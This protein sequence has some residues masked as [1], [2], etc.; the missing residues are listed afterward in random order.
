MPSRRHLQTKGG[1]GIAEA[2]TQR[3][4]A[5]AAA[6]ADAPA[7]L[8]DAAFAAV[9]AQALL[10][11]FRQARRPLPWRVTYAPYHVWVSEIMLQQTQMERGVSYFQRW[12]AELPDI[13]AVAAASE[14]T[15]LRLWEGLGYYSR[16][17]NLH[18]AAR[19]IMAEHGGVFPPSFEAIRALPGVGPYTA[20]AVASIA[21]QQ[22]VPCIDANVERVLAR[23]FDIGTPVK[24]EPAAARIRDLSACL[25]PHGQARDYNQA[26]MELGA[27]VCGKKPQCAVC[28]LACCCQA[29]HLGITADRPVPASKTAVKNVEAVTGILTHRGKVF[30]QKRLAGGL[31][32][33]LWEFPGGHVE[34]GEKP[35][36]AAVREYWEETGFRV[37]VREKLTVIR[38]N[39]TTYRITLHCYALALEGAEAEQDA[40]QPPVL[41]AATACRWEEEGPLAQWAMPAAHRKLADMRYGVEAGLRLPL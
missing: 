5:P 39:Y 18:K 33:G 27:L 19:V 35:E 34:E 29:R 23:V 20:A 37:R 40:P 4:I 3:P 6:P 41:T 38:H 28:P 7:P 10:G 21:F 14:E 1:Q 26:M 13:A 32:G 30:I 36:D 2:M 25:L 15:I 31:W 9:F 12:M 16:A 17:R 8:P 11:W 22:D 24:A